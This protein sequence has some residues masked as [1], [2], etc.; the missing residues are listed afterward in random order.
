MRYQAMRDCRFPSSSVIERI[1]YDDAATTLWVSF[2][3]AGTYLYD[4]VPEAVFEDFCLAPSAG[5]FFHER[6]KDR[7]SFRR[8]PARR[9]FGPN[10]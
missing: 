8:D 4:D 7:Y 5:T 9:R 6:I 3:G 10:A 1:A 2:S